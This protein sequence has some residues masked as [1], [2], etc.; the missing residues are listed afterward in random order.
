MYL[1]LEIFNQFTTCCLHTVWVKQVETKTNDL[2]ISINIYY[3]KI[4]AYLSITAFFNIRIKLLKNLV[5]YISQVQLPRFIFT[6]RNLK[7]ITAFVNHAMEFS[8]LM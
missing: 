3:V 6:C 7:W 5:F 4:L 1:T 8:L 2:C